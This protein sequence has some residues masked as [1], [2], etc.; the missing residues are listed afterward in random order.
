M[1]KEALLLLNDKYV[2]TKL[3]IDH[4][5]PVVSPKGEYYTYQPATIKVIKKP[6]KWYQFKQTEEYVEIPSGYRTSDG[7]VIYP[8]TDEKY[9][10]VNDMVY[11]SYRI[12]ITFF[13]KNGYID[14]KA[15]KDGSSTY[16]FYVY[17]EKEIDTIIAKFKKENTVDL[18]FSR[19]TTKIYG[20]TDIF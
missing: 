13:T 11:Y 19:N 5:K 7:D 18:E 1:T 15:K 16:N 2:V 12:E 14:P 3:W 9:M 8:H 6:R 17:S 4:C 20:K 10:I